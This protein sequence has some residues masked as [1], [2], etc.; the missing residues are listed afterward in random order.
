MS[1][2]LENDVQQPITEAGQ[3]FGKS[4]GRKAAKAGK[5]AAGKALQK[6]GTMASKAI[7]GAGKV[8]G[9]G[10]L[11]LIAPFLP[12][13]IGFF[14]LLLL[15][16]FTHDM[17]L[18]SRP[19]FQ[20]FQLELTSE[21]NQH[22][23]ETDE[24]GHYPITSISNGNKL[25][26]AFYTHFSD[27]SYW[28]VT[29]GS[30]DLSSPKGADDPEVDAKRIQDK[31]GRE[32]MFFLS[33]NALFALDEF[34]HDGDYRVPE[35]FIQPVPYEIDEKT[36]KMTLVDIY[37]EEKEKMN[38]KSTQYGEDGKPTG[39]KVNG[40]WDYGFAPVFHYKE[41]KEEMQYKGRVT[42][43]E[44]WDKERQEKVWVSASGKE[45]TNEETKVQ[46]LGKSWMI[47]Q[48]VSPGGTIR[49]DIKHDW[50]DTG[51]TWLPDPADYA[52]EKK[53][54]IRIWKYVQDRN[55]DG[56]KLY[57]AFEKE[58]PHIRWMTTEKTSTPIMTVV[59]DYEKQTRTFYKKVEGTR[60]EK[61]P[62][63]EGE[64]DFSDI[65]GTKYYRDYMAN[66]TTYLPEDVMTSFDI[67]K[68]LNTTDKKLEQLLDNSEDGS[69]LSMGTVNV[70]GLNLGAGASNENYTRAL[71]NL[72][73][74]EKYG[75]MYGVDPYLLVAIAARESSGSHYD[76]N[77]AVKVGAATGLMQ[78][79]RLGDR[80]VTA[81]NFETGS[82]ESFTVTN[83]SAKEIESNVKWA[84]MYV[85]SQMERYKYNFLKG[86][87]S[88][89][90][91]SFYRDT[92]WSVEASQSYQREV[93][94]GGG[95]ANYVHHVLQYYASPETPVPYVLTI[96]G[97]TVTM[98]NSDLPMGTVES[99]NGTI[100]QGQAGGG[101][102]NSINNVMRYGW[103]EI[104]Q[105]IKNTFG[106]EDKHVVKF[107]GVKEDEPRMKV[108]KG[109]NPDQTWEIIMSMMA[110]DEQKTLREYEGFTEEDFIERFK[111]MFTHPL[112]VSSMGSAGQSPTGINPEDYFSD[113]YVS[114]VTNPK[115]V[116]RFGFIEEKGKQVYN[117]GIGVTVA[118]GQN[119]MSVAKG[120]VVAVETKGTTQIVI[121]HSKGTTTVYKNVTDIKV[122]VGEQVRKGQTI[123]KGGSGGSFDFEMRQHERTQDPTWI[124][125]PT[126][127]TAGEGM[128]VI[129][130]SAKGLFQD[131][132]AGKPYVKTSPFGMRTHPIKGVRR[133][134]NGIDL[135]AT[136]GGGAPVHAV[137][138]GTA[139]VVAYSPGE[140]GNY[141]V[142][143]HGIITEVDTTRRMF[144]MYAHLQNGLSVKQGDT[145]KKGQ[146]LGGM[147]TTGGSTGNHLHFETAFGSSWN[148]KQ[149]V[150]PES[151]FDF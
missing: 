27:R 17:L 60:W 42:Q 14:L 89:N 76:K 12:Y 30:K 52:F 139:V 78:L 55:D 80:S 151:L 84:T 8:I 131:P 43:I 2:E 106:L 116:K 40:V 148:V 97:E 32:K 93:M 137:Y 122:K 109:K 87:Q 46:S 91:G 108:V 96:S 48:L 37:D 15:I 102:W 56:K 7:A 100:L 123:A 50:K 111:I 49:N 3:A 13:I 107:H 69:A 23:E 136:A 113:G 130:P 142:I 72:P 58:T 119:I 19:K 28:Y 79:E 62:E 144:T 68:R 105:G 24:D 34:M 86:L 141:V 104:S 138:D 64:P 54:D 85:A 101:L 112:G 92:D 10:I 70:E 44:K 82:K 47:D 67:A 73:I 16:M 90:F 140:L 77:G 53:V 150:N 143:D 81:H 63:Y 18:N 35:Q 45:A 127:L 98:D 65:T 25:V 22:A 115:V 29:E 75:K 147:G 146:K 20:D 149:R 126:V 51:Q 31:Y 125:D 121:E 36:G 59:P 120:M 94:K 110:Y 11:S 117:P 4:A 66:Y 71:E 74:F 88:Y 134:H 95:D 1:D 39:K 57:W 9:K 5:K 38:V 133:M 41:Y 99:I 135:V 103:S 26:R 129:D 6:G 118:S 61:V 33:P 124:V 83:E 145:V 128:I 21:R 114:P 132:F